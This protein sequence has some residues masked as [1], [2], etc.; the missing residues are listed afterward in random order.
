MSDVNSAASV[1]S[2]ANPGAETLAKTAST[3]Y[4]AALEVI[5]A[6]EP[7]VAEATRKELADQRGSL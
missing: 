6:V 2:G 7:R 3:A 1:D 4:D 5:A